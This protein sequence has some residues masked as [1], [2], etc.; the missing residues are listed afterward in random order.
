MVLE[1]TRVERDTF[2]PGQFLCDHGTIYLMGSPGA[3]HSVAPIVAALVEDVVNTARHQAAR[4]VTRRLESQLVLMLDECANIAPL[5]DLPKLVAE[6][7]GLGISTAVVLQS[8]ASARA[9]WGEAGER[10]LRD[11]ANV[12]LVWGGQKDI[13]FL[14]EISAL[15]G[16]H[17]E[18]V[19]TTT[20]S[21]SGRSV[22]WAPRRMPTLPVGDIAN[23]A[24][25]HA[26]VVS[27][28]L[29]PRIAYLPSWRD[30]R[31]L[32]ASIGPGGQ[33]TPNARR[34]A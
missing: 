31:A 28:H 27:A 24:R 9:I 4:S 13:A 11:L 15:A 33:A 12:T 34:R 14:E 30:D 17:D 10:A 16:E 18:L 23:L 6:L 19:E 29:R 22:S 7:G 32:V 1:A 21:E 20:E 2:D 25:N 26:V 5:G 8:V 3:Q